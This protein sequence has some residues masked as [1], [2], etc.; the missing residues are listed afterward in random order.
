MGAR[1]DRGQLRI[2]D[3]GRHRAV[4][5]HL[6]HEVEK[7]ALHVVHVAVAVHVLAIEVG[8]DRQ[9]G[10]ELEKRAVALVGF[11]DQILRPAQPR[12]RAHGI[13]ASADHDGG[14]EAA[15]A[16]HA[17]HHR[18]GRGLA[19]H[20]GDGDAVLEAHQFGQ[21]FGALDDGNFAR[22]RF[23]HFGIGGIDR[24]TGHHHRGPLDMGGLVAFIDH[25]A[26]LGEAIGDGAAAQVGTGDFHFLVEQDLG[27]AAHADAADAN[28]MG[29]LG[30]GEHY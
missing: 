28:E 11:G 23:Q 20:A 22:A 30:S 26:Q 10:R 1:Q 21:H 27:D 14:I 3:A 5:R 9:D 12:V 16:K 7:G 4:E 8:H 6:V 24:G 17:G 18:G 29:V 15:G 13:D 25:G 2:V 19:V